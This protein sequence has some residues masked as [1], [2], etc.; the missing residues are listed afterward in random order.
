T[1]NS[2]YSKNQLIPN[3]TL[4]I[5]ADTSVLDLMKLRFACDWT[6]REISIDW[7]ACGIG[8]K[9][10]CCVRLD[11]KNSDSYKTDELKIFHVRKLIMNRVN[12]IQPQN[13]QAQRHPTANGFQRTQNIANLPINTST[14]VQKYNDLVE[15]WNPFS[16]LQDSRIPI[17]D[18]ESPNALFLGLSFP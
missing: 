3:E 7:S 4:N 16:G 2:Q 5:T 14:A 8:T 10:D 9:I 6:I 1:I 13:N 15:G 18:I 12:N 11:L 17:Q